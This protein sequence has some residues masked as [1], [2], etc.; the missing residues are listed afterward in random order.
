[1]ISMVKIRGNIDNWETV[2]FS[3]E[4]KENYQR[5]RLRTIYPHLLVWEAGRIRLQ[6]ADRI[7]NCCNQ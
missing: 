3:V 7:V 4:R 5:G 1:M 2:R 6:N